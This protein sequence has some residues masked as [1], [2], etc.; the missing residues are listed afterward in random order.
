MRKDHGWQRGP[1]DKRTRFEWFSVVSLACAF[2]LVLGVATIS[3]RRRIAVDI[4]EDRSWNQ[5][6]VL[7]VDEASATMTTLA[8][9]W[10]ET[11]VYGCTH[12]AYDNS[13]ALGSHS[14]HGDGYSVHLC[15]GR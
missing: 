1:T 8:F 4:P 3:G 14:L 6:P 15:E 10:S 7:S 13:N 2:G 11:L 5:R 12:V 9:S